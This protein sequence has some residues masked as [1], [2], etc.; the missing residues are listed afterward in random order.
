MQPILVLANPRVK[1]YLQPIVQMLKLLHSQLLARTGLLDQLPQLRAKRLEFMLR[2]R[3]QRNP[4]TP[5]FQERRHPGPVL[6]HVR[7][8]AVSVPKLAIH[9]V[10]PGGGTT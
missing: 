6:Q 2:K 4:E 3:L 5:V 9:Q 1:V 7:E 8:I 10:E